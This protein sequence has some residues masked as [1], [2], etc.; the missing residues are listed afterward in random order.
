M[1][2]RSESAGF[3]EF[4][5]Y[6]RNVAVE[7]GTFGQQFHIEIEPDDK[8]LLKQSKTGK[9][10]EWLRISPK[11]TESSVPEGS[12]LDMYLRE[13]ESTFREAKKEETVI[14]ALKVLL[15]KKVL[16]KKKRL[17]KKFEGKEAAE[18]W[19]PVRYLG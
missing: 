15:N 5:G 16:Y 9:F 1:V 10:H 14:G 19:V 7:Q 3:E 6:A 13:I 8:S 17:G 11:T 2:E 12:I 18:H 4:V